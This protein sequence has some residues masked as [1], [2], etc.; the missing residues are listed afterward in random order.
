MRHQHDS[1]PR[2]KGKHKAIYTDS[3]HQKAECKRQEP[4]HGKSKTTFIQEHPSPPT[5]MDPLDDNAY[6]RIFQRE[7][8]SPHE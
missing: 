3:L 6:N 2:H 8:C 5:T 7:S 4:Y 1:E